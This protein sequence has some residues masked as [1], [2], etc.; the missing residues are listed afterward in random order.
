MNSSTLHGVRLR[1]LKSLGVQLRPPRGEPYAQHV[2]SYSD[3]SDWDMPPYERGT[4]T[5]CLLSS[6]P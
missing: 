6:P 3:G 5:L 1:L 2:Y 4:S